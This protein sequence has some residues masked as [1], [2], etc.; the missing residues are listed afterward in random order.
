MEQSLKINLNEGETLLWSGRPE[1]F[2]TLDA[3]HKSNFILRLIIGLGACA[4]LIGVYVHFAGL[5]NV[6]VKPMILAL[7]AA[8]C[9]F[10]PLSVYA[11]AAKL[12]KSVLYAVTD[13]RLMLI[14]ESVY[15]VPYSSVKQAALK[16]DA[17]GHM[18][19]LCGGKALKYRPAR[20]RVAA[21]VG[22]EI[23]EKDGSCE[24]FTL[25][26]LPQDEALN[27]ILKERLPLDA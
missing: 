13:Q 11:D 9:L 5:N 10:S 19:L 24:S 22:D 16:K 23:S 18:S 14:R 20:W 8:L 25:Y 26:A 2:D 17:D 4:L 3:T 21:L 6:E 7:M 12:R 27:A 1:R 15:Q